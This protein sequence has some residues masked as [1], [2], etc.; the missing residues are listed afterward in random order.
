MGRT[1]KMLQ[2]RRPAFTEVTMLSWKEAGCFMG[3]P[4]ISLK[5]IPLQVYLYSPFSFTV[6][7]L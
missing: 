3:V 2:A 7:H 4:F 5:E 6:Q 1:A